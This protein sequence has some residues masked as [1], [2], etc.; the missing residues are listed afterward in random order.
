MKKIGIL[1]LATLLT[2]LA[3]QAEMI[4]VGGD[5]NSTGDPAWITINQDI[6][7]TVTAD[8]EFQL[9]VFD[10]IVTSDGDGNGINFL[11]LEFSINGGSKIALDFW[12]DNMAS[13]AGDITP[14]DGFILG[15]TTNLVEGTI[16]TLHAGTG[17]ATSTAPN[18]NLWASGDVNIFLADV[19]AVAMSNVI[20]KPAAITLIALTGLGV[21]FTRRTF[22]R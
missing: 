20:P 11:G 3:V 6:N 10:E 2:G 16:V 17:T 19:D 1:S 22:M 15:D 18:F 13:T 4:T 8:G 9:F 21:I 14:N 7:F 12:I 5:P